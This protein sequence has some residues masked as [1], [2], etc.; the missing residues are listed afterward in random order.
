MTP[1]GIKSWAIPNWPKT[2]D[3]TGGGDGHACVLIGSVS[4]SGG[5]PIGIAVDRPDWL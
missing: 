5:F 2:R 4:T 1:S 3:L